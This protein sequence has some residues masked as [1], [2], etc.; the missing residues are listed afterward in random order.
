M[1]KIVLAFR[2]KMQNSSQ[3]GDQNSCWIQ[4][5]LTN[6]YFCYIACVLECIAKGSAKTRLVQNP[7]AILPK[8]WMKS[9]PSPNSNCFTLTHLRYR[10]LY[11]LTFIKLQN[12]LA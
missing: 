1:Q 2:L 4:V 3:N 9:V 6:M 8:G 7:D 12:D 10:L 5:K 11:K